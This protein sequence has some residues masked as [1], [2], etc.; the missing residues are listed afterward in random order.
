MVHRKNRINQMNCV[1]ARMD[2]DPGTRFPWTPNQTSPILWKYST[3]HSKSDNRIVH[4]CAKHDCCDIYYT[5]TATSEYA[6]PRNTIR[7]LSD[8][9]IRKPI[10]HRNHT[11]IV[12]EVSLWRYEDQTLGNVIG[13]LTVFGFE[14]HLLILIFNSFFCQRRNKFK[15]IK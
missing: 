12:I 13:I 4:C 2:F 9:V 8:V 5:N 7:D 3:R 14:I 11:A 6:K 15:V 1:V 10:N